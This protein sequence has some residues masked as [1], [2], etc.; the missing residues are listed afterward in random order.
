M[1]QKANE[2]LMEVTKY[3]P[4]HWTSRFE[5]LGKEDDPKDSTLNE[6]V[7]LELKPLPSNL[8][9]EFLDSHFKLPFIVN[10]SLPSDNVDA[11]M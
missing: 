8:R 5:P 7:K 3:K 9:Y 2:Q 1:V 6:E 4:S 11:F 10:S